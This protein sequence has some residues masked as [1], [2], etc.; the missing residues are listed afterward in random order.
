[1]EHSPTDPNPDWAE[2]K[3][4]IETLAW[5]KALGGKHGIDAGGVAWHFQPVELV[6]GFRTV[7]NENDLK[8]LKVPRGQLTFD[9]EGN[10][11]DDPTRSL[12]KYFSRIAHWPGGVSG[13]TIGRGYDLGQRPDPEN[14]LT[15]AGI[16]DSLRSWLIGAKGLKGNNAKTYLNNANQQIKQATITRKQQYELFLPVYDFMK[17]EV[18]RISDTPANVE[19][20]GRLHWDTIDGR[21]QDIAI[22]L[23]YRG[24]YT[25]HTREH[26]QKHIVENNLDKLKEILSDESKWTNVP[27]DRF[28]RRIEYLK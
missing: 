19:K 5:W 9:V 15:T 20:Y 11:I 7:D 22:D 24:D 21:I 10:D 28:N 14:N 26:V 8:W 23:I 25:S 12:Y 27:E 13:V 6:T 16:K 4:R 3:K 1:M 18:I 2:E 17:G